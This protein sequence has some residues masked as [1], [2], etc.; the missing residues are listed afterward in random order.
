MAYGLPLL[1]KDLIEQSA[2]RRTYVLRVIYAVVLYGA[3]LWVYADVAGGGAQAGMSSL[4]RGRAMFD[5]LATVQLL[6]IAILLPGISCGAVTS[7]KER[8]TLGLLLLTKLGPWTIVM[9][10]FISRL[11]TMGTYQLLSLPLFAVVY[12]MGGV[13]LFEIVTAIWYLGCWSILI[14]AWSIYCSTWHRTTAGA[15]IASYSIMPIVICFGTTGLNTM[16]PTMVDFWRRAGS[17]SGFLFLAQVAAAVVV[18]FVMSLPMLGLAM[19]ALAAARVQLLERAFV[20]QRNLL[21]EFFRLLDGFFEELNQ[22]TTR[23]IVLVREHDTGPVFDPIAWRE[24]RK[25]SLGTVRYLFR[26]LVV[27]EV[28]LAIAI[29]WTIADMQVYSFD[30][31]TLF[32][33][34][35]LWPVAALAITVHATNVMAS[36]RS[37][38]TLD[39]LLVAPFTPAE[40]VT[41][42]L[43]GVRRLIGIL[44]I[45][46]L[47]LVIFQSIWKLYVVRGL[48]LFRASAETIVFIHEI[49]GMTVAMLI[50]PRV[51][52]WLAFGISLKI[53]NQTQAVLLTV[54]AIT[55]ICAIPLLLALWLR[56]TSLHDIVDLAAW[57]SP[58]R[59]LFHRRIVEMG[60]RDATLGDLH[61]LGLILHTAVGIVTWLLLR[62]FALRNF[63]F[64]M[65]R[66]E[67][68]EAPGC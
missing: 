25:K 56:S 41:Q 60:S 13:E 49:I 59:L 67:P 10:K 66:T 46:F 2:H 17:Q 32:F 51:I 62:H 18:L 53:K 26:L 34:A 50:Y 31:P 12:G 14:G 35:M 3:A 27:L 19:V 20:P 11:V 48:N 22:Q 9:E 42:K 24:T 52:Q 36:E 4:G 64:W 40:L 68:A 21:L 39:V 43:A 30:G 55:G 47:T 45:P 6:A 5:M 1:T 63:S 8:D 65:G 37:R 57:L 15:F 44:T 38:Q 54:A 58:V 7:E 61:Y 23:G 29:S 16:M 33:L 28:P